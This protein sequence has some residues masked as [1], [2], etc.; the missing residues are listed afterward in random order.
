LLKIK[1][2]VVK[3]KEFY[4]HKNYPL[5]INLNITIAESYL[6][7]IISIWNYFSKTL[8]Y[9][10]KIRSYKLVAKN[11]KKFHIFKKLS[12]IA[13]HNCQ[14]SLK[15]KMKMGKKQI[16][17]KKVKTFKKKREKIT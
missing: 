16:H 12:I 7:L 4:Q 6:A 11:M 2:E 5:K 9:L 3:L 13:M 10:K 1:V 15:T 8:S 17:L 14:K